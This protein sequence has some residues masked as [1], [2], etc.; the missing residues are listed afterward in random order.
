MTA[1]PVMARLFLA[2]WPDAAVRAGLAGWRDR[3]GWPAGAAVVPTPKLHLTLHF[4]GAVPAG[5]LGAVAD[6]LQVRVPPAFDLWFDRVAAWPRGLVALETGR[7]PPPQLVE[8]HRALAAALQ[9]LGL[10]VERRRLRPH[11]TLARR[12]TGARLAEPGEPLRWRVDGYALVRSHLGR[13][14]ADQA[15]EVLRRYR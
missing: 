15:Y 14:D 6:G 8:L 2:L 12:A 4:I 13:D 3:C 7:A 1:P 11:V 10:P 5:Q 9:A